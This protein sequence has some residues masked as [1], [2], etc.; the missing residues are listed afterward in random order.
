MVL[1]AGQ[2]NNEVYTFE[3]MLKED[4]RAGFVEAMTKEIEIHERR[5]HWMVVSRTSM[6]SNTKTIQS[7]CAFKW[8]RFPEGTLTKH[9]TILCAHGGMQQ[10]GVN[11]WEIYAPVVNWISIRFLLIVAEIVGL[12]SKAIDFVLAFPQADFDVPVYMELPL[13]TEIPGA[14]Y[15]R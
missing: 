1:E 6:P 13:G 8:K 3:D 10:W 14:A 4:D 12:E 2:T 15:N 11:F 7:I 9:K 5:G